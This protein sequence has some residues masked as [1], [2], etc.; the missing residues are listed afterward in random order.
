METQTFT[1]SDLEQMLNLVPAKSRPFA[2]DLV[3]KSKKYQLSDKQLFWVDRLTREAAGLLDQP[4]PESSQLANFAGVYELFQKAS[5]NLKFPKIRMQTEDGLPVVLYVSGPN[6]KAPG[7]VT[8]TD[9]QPF[10]QNRFYGR[11]T[12]DGKWE[13]GSSYPEKGA[14]RGLL[15]KLADKPA[16]TAAEYGR[17]TGRCCFCGSS[18]KDENS[19]AVGYGPVCAKNY[20]LPYG[21]ATPVLHA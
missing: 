21:V 19:T 15:T 14:I 7:V 5:K 10:G 13:G 20:G 8:V 16:E 3:V 9:G 17:L 4:K 11:V 18:L 1:P 2:A 6:S 12:K